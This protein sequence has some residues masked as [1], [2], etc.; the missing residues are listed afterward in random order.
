MTSTLISH[1]GRTRRLAVVIIST[2]TLLLGMGAAVAGTGSSAS[3]PVAPTSGA[4][5]AVTT[6]TV[7]PL[8]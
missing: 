5:P 2:A 1:T 6:T 8:P 7:T 3:G 4:T